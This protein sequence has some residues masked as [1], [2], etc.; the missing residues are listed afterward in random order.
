MNDPTGM[1][2]RGS[3]WSDKDWEKFDK[4]QKQAASDMSS[5]A[6]SMREDAAGLKD[7][8]TSA[9]GYSASELNS[10]AD[11]LDAGAAALNDDGSDGYTAHA[12]TN[13]DNPLKYGEAT[14]SKTIT[15]A[16][17]HPDFT[18]SDTSRLRWNAGHESL[19]NAGM[20][21]PKWRGFVPYRYGIFGQRKSFE[22]LP[23]DR[24]SSNPDHLLKRVYP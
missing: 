21:H 11:K 3:G 6:S 23:Q 10:M 24:R 7:G 20:S 4:A 15:I 1:Y 16:T 8:A 17:E 12:V 14:G 9:D 2:G 13:F 22:D 18:N 5:A 19:H